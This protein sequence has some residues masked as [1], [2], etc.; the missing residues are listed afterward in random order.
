MNKNYRVQHHAEKCAS[1]RNFDAIR[2]A[3]HFGDKGKIKIMICSLDHLEIEKAG[4]CDFYK[5]R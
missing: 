1:C 3:I 2:E 4:V 5:S